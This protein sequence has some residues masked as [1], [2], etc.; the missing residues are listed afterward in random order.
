MN[1]K[2]LIPNIL[3]LAAIFSPSWSVCAKD[4]EQDLI[5]SG[6]VHSPL[7]L[8]R[9]NS[10]DAKAWKK[11]V[12]LEKPLDITKGWT[13][14]GYGTLEV[15]ANSSRV[16]M[17]YASSTGKRARGPVD[18]PDYCIYGNASLHFDMGGA[19]IEQFNRIVFKVKPICPGKRVMN[20]NFYLANDRNAPQK[21]GYN[22]PTGDHLLNLEPGKWNDCYLE[23]ADLQRDCVKELRFSVSLNGVD[24]T[25][26]DSVTYLIEDIRLQNIENPEK[27]IGWQP[28]DDTII[29]SMTGYDSTGNKTAIVSSE[30]A[31]KVS[32]FSLVSTADCSVAYKGKVDKVD[33]TIG[34]FGE[35]DFTSFTTP[36]EYYLVV[37]NTKTRP[38]AIG[39]RSIWDNSQWRVVNFIFGQRCG[40]SIP[41]IHGKCHT[42]LFA[43]HNGMRIP[44]SGGWHDA[45]DLSQQTLQTAD[46]AYS[47][48]Q[49][50]NKA[51]EHNPLLAAR[52]QEEA[53]WG[54]DFALRTRFGDGYRASSMGL[55]I[56]QDG[57][58]DSFDDIVT[59]RVQNISLDNYYY[60]A[61]FA[62][63]AM[64]LEGDPAFKEYL[65]RIAI[66]DFNFAE[67]EFAK[68]GFG[69]FIS[70]MEH[71]YNTSKSQWMATIAWSASQLY[72]LTGDKKYAEK[73]SD[74]IEYTLACQQTEPIGKDGYQGFF[75]R[76]KERKAIVHYIHQS[77]EQ[78][79]IEALDALC[80][81]QPEN[82]AV[83]Q[84]KKSAH[85]YGEYLKSLMKYT[86][87]YGMIP[88]GIYRDD[89]YLDEDSFYHLHLFPPANATELY[90]T[91]LLQG[92]K[93]DEHFYVK[94]FPIWFSIFNGN[95]AV[96]TSMGKS[97]AILGKLLNDSELTNIAREQLYWIVGKNPFAQSLIYGEGHDYPMMNSFSSG[98]I[99]GEMPVG[100]RSYGNSDEP[101]FPQINNACY[102]EVWLTSAGKWLSLLSEF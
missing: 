70:Q 24:Q 7:P 40:H 67:A 5:Q 58:T 57:L 74:A 22:S 55:L 25:T 84:W 8:D 37:G 26:G 51:K 97:A 98:E 42:D 76:E 18:D 64:N 6:Y 56:W 90:T 99:T 1:Y 29:Y 38:F 44:Y 66:E 14:S 31:N 77:R 47:L 28:E 15:N 13:H 12:L 3:L 79:F 39:G 101:Y 16:A 60:A 27:I 95:I 20:I 54:L 33:T 63:A 11:K 71:I 4:F 78:I 102:K 36:G 52:L 32:E 41:G 9:E 21:E 96:H 34:T 46:V 23:I 80:R 10:L 93:I 43:V 62:Y 83:E 59:V 48:L 69:G 49:A 73:A 50:S 19:N 35:L 87:P 45:G 30:T 75:Y 68:T 82:P 85:L 91:Q 89:E 100:I 86:L 92:E 72:A 2:Q 88:S 81:T 94:R 65:R 17:T 53:L 61:Y